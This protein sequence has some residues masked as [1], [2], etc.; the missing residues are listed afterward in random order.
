MTSETTNIPIY[1]D[2][3]YDNRTYSLLLAQL[4]DEDKLYIKSNNYTV[5]EVLFS[6]WKSILCSLPSN[7]IDEYNQLTTNQSRNDWLEKYLALPS[8]DMLEMPD[9][10]LN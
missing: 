5:H 6:R 8:K 1:S 9:S 2:D 7:Y 3:T 4:T 10:L